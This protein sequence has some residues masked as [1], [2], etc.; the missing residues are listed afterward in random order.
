[1]SRKGWLRA[2][3]ASLAL[4]MAFAQAAQ[5][6]KIVV[7]GGGGMIG[8]RVVPVAPRPDDFRHIVVRSDGKTVA[9][10]WRAGLISWHDV[11][12]SYRLPLR[13]YDLDP[14]DWRYSLET[15]LI[16]GRSFAQELL[17]WRHG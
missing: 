12:H 17:G 7:I 4:G 2:V 5:P 3:V 11:R 16:A 15:L 9:A 10:Y 13:F 14:R 8:Q 1:M 6:L